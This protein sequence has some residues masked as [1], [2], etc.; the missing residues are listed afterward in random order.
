MA[1]YMTLPCT[2]SRETYPDNRIGKYTTTLARPLELEGAWEVGLSEIMLPQIGVYL[3]N[4]AKVQ[5]IDP[6]AEVKDVASYVMPHVIIP[7]GLQQF[8]KLQRF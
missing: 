4:D 1:F 6:N 7:K 8:T 2:A 3:E 5:Y